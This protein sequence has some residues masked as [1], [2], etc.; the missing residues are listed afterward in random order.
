MSVKIQVGV[1]WVWSR[2]SVVVGYQSFG[3][4]CCLHL[5]DEVTVSN[6]W[7]LWNVASP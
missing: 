1:F 5:Q 6:R 3:G 2:C 4:P 7:I